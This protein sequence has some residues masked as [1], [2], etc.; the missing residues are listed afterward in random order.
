M[1]GDWRAATQA[2]SGSEPIDVL[3]PTLVGSDGAVAEM[4]LIASTMKFSCWWQ[5][6]ETAVVFWEEKT[7][8]SSDQSGRHIEPRQK[9][10]RGQ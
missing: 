9:N 1:I 3:V 4:G 8:R 10:T 2:L 5:F 7:E 6:G